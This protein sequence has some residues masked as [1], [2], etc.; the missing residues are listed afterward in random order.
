MISVAHAQAAAPA[1]GSAFGLDGLSSMMLPLL[2]IGAMY[3]L[4]IRPQQKRAKETKAM[5]DALK[6]GDEVITAGG[7]LGKITKA[8]EQ[9]VVVEIAAGSEI[10]VQRV[11]VTQVLP[12]GTLKSI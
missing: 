8:N 11:A 2:M 5:V 6:N 4:M 3:F 7:I 1:T 12:K 10:T 9:Y